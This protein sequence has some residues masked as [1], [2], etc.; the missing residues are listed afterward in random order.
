MAPLI[1][2]KRTTPTVSENVEFY[3]KGEIPESSANIFSHVKVILTICGHPITAKTSP[4]GFDFQIDIHKLHAS[5]SS[6]PAGLDG[7][8]LINLP[9]YFDGQTTDCPIKTYHMKLFEEGGSTVNT[10]VT[11]FSDQE[12]GGTDFVQAGFSIEGI[13]LKVEYND[14]TTFTINI[15]PTIPSVT[16]FPA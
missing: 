1:V 8:K 10:A 6:V 11:P 14:V 16:P 13:N 15:K 3:L 7:V 5:S 2:I 4:P 12:A 9:Q